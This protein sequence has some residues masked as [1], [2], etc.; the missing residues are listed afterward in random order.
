[1]KKLLQKYMLEQLLTFSKEI[2][3]KGYLLPVSSR[4]ILSNTF[5]CS[6]ALGLNKENQELCHTEGIK[7]L[8]LLWT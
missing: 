4:G 2:T 5:L 8:R 1:M 7:E 3:V 6:L